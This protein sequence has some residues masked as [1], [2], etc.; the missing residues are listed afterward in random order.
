MKTVDLI[1]S[2]DDVALLGPCKNNDA[3]VR[4]TVEL[5]VECS[6]VPAK[7]ELVAKKEI[8]ALWQICTKTC[9]LSLGWEMLRIHKHKLTQISSCLGHK[10]FL[11]MSNMS[12]AEIRTPLDP[13]AQ[14]AVQAREVR[15]KCCTT[16][17]MLLALTLLVLAAVA[18]GVYFFFVH[19]KLQLNC[20]IDECQD[21]FLPNDA[22]SCAD[23]RCNRCS[24]NLK[25][26]VD[27]QGGFCGLVCSV[28]HCSS[29][30]VAGRGASNCSQWR[31]PCPRCE[32]G[33]EF[34]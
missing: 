11:S 31:Q 17:R 20:S 23:A 12:A 8:K 25:A 15:P 6:L 7:K 29:N 26:S 19:Q 5:R 18:A 9:D 32:E 24:G 14:E 28:E 13:E 33:W 1:D 4:V 2:D 21:I 34:Q 22:K 16:C 3:A 10:A 30:V 27:S